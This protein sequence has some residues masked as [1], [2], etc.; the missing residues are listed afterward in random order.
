MTLFITGAAGF[1]G[2]SFL[3]ISKN[4][5]QYS[6]IVVLDA[7][8][9]AGRMENI[10]GL[11]D[12]K[13]I[14]FEKVDIRDFDQVTT[15]FKKYQPDS[16]VNFAAESHVDN[17]ISGPRVF[18][19][20][21]VIGTLNLLEASR[22]LFHAADTSCQSKFRFVHVST[23][24]VFGQLGDT[25]FFNE[26]TAYDPSSPY[27]ASKAGSDHLARAW[28]HTY[29]LPTIVTNCSNNY[30]PRQFPEKLIPRMILNCLEGKK[31]PVYGKGVNVRDW[32]YVDD[33]SEGIYLALTKGTPGE[34]YCL[35][36]NSERKNIDVV[37]TICAILDKKRPKAGGGSY[38]SLIEFVEDRKG[39]DFRYAIDDSHAM[40]TLGYKRRFKTFEEGLEATIN[41]YLENNQ[42]IQDISNNGKKA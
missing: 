8:T 11:V 18:I 36:G 3:R 14:F 35:G 42:W 31:L 12:N 40:N 19:E 33:H 4:H 6:K 16:V 5:N 9:Y 22:A 1:I 21:N 28:N 41:W 27:S 26:K 20:T 24:E 30:G 7:L 32:I 15:V 13:N 39:H 17:S 10:E 23:D 37:K 25:G 38:E 29:K 2:S 34:T